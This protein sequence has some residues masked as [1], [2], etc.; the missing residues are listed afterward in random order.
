[1]YLKETENEHHIFRAKTSAGEDVIIKFTYEGGIAFPRLE[2]E[3][4]IYLDYLKPLWGV[5]VPKFYGLYMYTSSDIYELTCACI[6]LQYCGEPA[7][8]D[9]SQLEDYCSDEYG[10]KQ[11]RNDTM[12]MVFRLHSLGL[13]HDELNASHILDFE[14]KPFLVDFTGAE[15]HC[16]L[17]LDDL[18]ELSRDTL[19]AKEG[20]ILRH[21]GRDSVRCYELWMFIKS[22]EWC[23]PGMS[24]MKRQMLKLILSLQQPQLNI[25]E[26]PI[27]ARV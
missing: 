16:C 3:S 18:G 19:P 12:D 22:I 23:L 14:G 9:L 26:D 11:F 6:I 5:H 21:I 25:T 1:M 27:V 15:S 4:Q 17:A 10:I 13:E 2:H 7:V 8:S 20:E 24:V